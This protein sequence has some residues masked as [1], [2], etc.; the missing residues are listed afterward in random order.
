MAG[1]VQHIC[2]A[3]RA[4]LRRQ[5]PVLNEKGELFPGNNNAD[6]S[7]DSGLAEYVHGKIVL[8]VELQ[9]FSYIVNC[10]TRRIAAVIRYF[11]KL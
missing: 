11:R 10:I 1:G 8:I 2:K 9:A 4:G 5:N 7:A 6:C 3:D